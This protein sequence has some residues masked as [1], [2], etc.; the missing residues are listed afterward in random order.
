MWMWWVG[1]EVAMRRDPWWDVFASHSL[2]GLD[3]VRVGH[4]V[5]RE[6]G[7]PNGRIR[8]KGHW[9][10]TGGGAGHRIPYRDEKKDAVEDVQ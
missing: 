3:V 6:S 5:W 2:A 4:Q 1:E 10:R 7:D 8:K 9:R